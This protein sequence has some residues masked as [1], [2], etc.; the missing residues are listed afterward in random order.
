M[1]NPLVQRISRLQQQ[2]AQKRREFLGD[3]GRIDGEEQQRLDALQGRIDRTV[4]ELERRGTPVT[5]VTF[6]DDEPHRVEVP[7]SRGDAGV[8]GVQQIGELLERLK[9]AIGNFWDN[10]SEGLGNFADQMRTESDQSAEPRHAREVFKALAKHAFE[11]GLSEVGE[12]LGGPWG[13][14]IAGAKAAVEAWVAETERVEAATGQIQVTDYIRS[15]RTGI[16]NLKG[17]IFSAVDARR[18]ALRQQFQQTASQDFG[19]GRPVPDAQRPGA[20]IVGES[21]RVLNE[22]RQSV[23]RYEANVRRTYSPAYFERQFASRFASRSGV[24]DFISQGGR[25]SG[26]LHFHIHACKDPENNRWTVEEKDDAWTLA[27]TA[28]DPDRIASSLTRSLDGR[29]P[30]QL[31]L[32]KLVGLRVSIE[33]FGFNDYQEGSIFFERGPDQFEVRSHQP[34]DLFR[35]AW[36]NREIRNAVL[37]V[38]RLVGSS[39]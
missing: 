23:E 7:V 39:D 14:I 24:T 4:R 5:G 6:A 3:D 36:S 15:L 28:P 16:G 37:N 31:E 12:R 29:K 22:L 13:Q 1:S 32:P 25:L 9:R 2:L 10:Y 26:T 35:E 30:W 19:G 11:E 34:P 27:T 38:A 17:Q 33:T 8:D 20:A 18:S 21:A